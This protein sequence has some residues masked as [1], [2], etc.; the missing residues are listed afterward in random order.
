MPPII[1]VSHL[2]KNFEIYQHHR[3]FW[4]TLQNLTTRYYILV[5]AVDQLSFEIQPGELVGYLGSNGTG[6]LTTIKMLSGLLVPSGGE[7]W[8]NNCVP[9]QERKAYVATIGAMFG[10]RATLWWNLP[11]IESLDLL[12]YVYDMLTDRLQRDLADRRIYEDRLRE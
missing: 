6:K 11:V 3:G 9:W 8:V 7:L 5:K 12:Q 4:G 1:L 10:Q 2:Q